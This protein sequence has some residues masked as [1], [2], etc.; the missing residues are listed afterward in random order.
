M[1]GSVTD[2]VSIQRGHDT[3]AGAPDLATLCFRL[4]LPW[5]KAIAG[6]HGDWYDLDPR[7]AQRFLPFPDSPLDNKGNEAIPQAEVIVQFRL[8][9]TSLTLYHTGCIVLDSHPL[10]LVGTC[11]GSTTWADASLVVFL[12]DPN[13]DIFWQAY[14]SPVINHLFEGVGKLLERSGRKGWIFEGAKCIEWTGTFLGKRDHH[15]YTGLDGCPTPV[16][17]K[18]T[19]E[20]QD[21]NTFNSRGSLNRRRLPNNS[22]FLWRHICF[23]HGISGRQ[24][25]SLDYH[26]SLCRFPVRPLLP[27]LLPRSRF[28]IHPSSTYLAST[29]GLFPI[30]A[31]LRRLPHRTSGSLSVP[32]AELGACGSHGPECSTPEKASQPTKIKPVS[33]G[34][35]KEYRTEYRIIFSYSVSYAY[36]DESA[37][38]QG[39][40]LDYF[41][42]KSTST[43]GKTIAIDDSHPRVKYSGGWNSTS[44]FEPEDENQTPGPDGPAVGE[45]DGE[46]SDWED[47]DQG[48][49]DGEGRCW[50]LDITI[51]GTISIAQWLE[52]APVQMGRSQVKF[53]VEPSFGS[54]HVRS[55]S[56]LISVKRKKQRIRR[57]CHTALITLALPP[58][59]KRK[60]DDITSS[61]LKVV[62]TTEPPTKRPKWSRNASQSTMGRLLSAA[63]FFVRGVNPYMDIGAAMLYGPEH[64]WSTPAAADPSN[65]VVIPPSR[66]FNLIMTLL[67][68]SFFQ[69]DL[70]PVVKQLYLYVLEEA[71]CPKCPE[72]DQN[73]ALNGH[74]H[75]RALAEGYTYVY[76]RATG[77]SVVFKVKVSNVVLFC[78]CGGAGNSGR[79]AWGGLEKY[80]RR[81]WSA[82]RVERVC[83]VVD[84]GPEGLVPVVLPSVTVS[85]LHELLQPHRHGVGFSMW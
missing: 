10:I 72:N 83:V 37:G 24:N 1:R 14:V 74:S 56:C 4:T 62:S 32:P 55:H 65:T 20:F 17:R 16:A 9:F 59:L 36:Y 68:E 28:S 19:E 71:L 82:S 70:L 29:S 18:S 76:H 80:L 12:D 51:V 13:D 67:L 45:E 15:V 78:E 57:A 3:L 25:L 47:L 38:S 79:K 46:K 44:G 54:F 33:C 61:V 41:S 69:H 35:R 7:D 34:E 60:C 30:K 64:H 6:A 27:L 84:V 39:I 11:R 26:I 43:A 53:L 31:H 2:P 21:F 66:R 58:A 50:N 85:C 49:E 5:E 73:L 77:F 48:D 75:L 52:L 63:K 22:T 42:Y 40:W 23:L 81:C 8:S